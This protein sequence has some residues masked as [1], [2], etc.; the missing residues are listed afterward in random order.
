MVLSTHL[1]QLDLSPKMPPQGPN[2]LR[3]MTVH[4]A[5]GL[6]FEHVYLIGMAQEVFPSFHAL[7]KGPTSREVEEERRSCF[8]ATTRARKTLTL[9]RSSRYFGYAKRASQFLGEMGIGGAG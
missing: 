1:Q 2:A 3:C 9:T 8:V 6:E 4:G 7:R 5:K